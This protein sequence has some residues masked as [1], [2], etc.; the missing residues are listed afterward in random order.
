MAIVKPVIFT[1][2]EDAECVRNRP[3]SEEVVRKLIQNSN[4]LAA[5]AVIGSLRTIALNQAGVVAPNT[6]QWQL[7]DGSQIVHPQSPITSITPTN[8]FTPDFTGKYIRGAFSTTVNNV[9]GA[10]SVNL[11]HFHGVGSVCVGLSGEEG[12]EQNAYGNGCHSH[13]I[14]NDLDPAEILELAHQQIA[15]YLKIN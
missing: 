11:S 6:D 12:D 4:M 9:G 15:V 14:F 3:V 1:P 5:L 7:S 10:P 2:V 8:R 13:S